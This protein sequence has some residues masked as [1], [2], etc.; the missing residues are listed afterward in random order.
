MR[1]DHAVHDEFRGA[2]LKIITTNSLP[3][4]WKEQGL[5]IRYIDFSGGLD[6]GHFRGDSTL[7]PRIILALERKQINDTTPNNNH[8]K[9]IK[10]TAQQQTVPC[11]ILFHFLLIHTLPYL[12]GYHIT[13]SSYCN[14]EK[15][16]TKHN[17]NIISPI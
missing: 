3:V 9:I 10:S 17:N 8:K 14:N 12:V 13:T 6:P 5:G 1:I 15:Q 7:A 16:F 11:C 2:F 4:D